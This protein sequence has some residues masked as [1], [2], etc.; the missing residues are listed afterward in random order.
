M[1]VRR[2]VL[3]LCAL[4]GLGFLSQLGWRAYIACLM[5]RGDYV[6]LEHFGGDRYFLPAVRRLYSPQGKSAECRSGLADWATRRYQTRFPSEDVYD[7]ASIPGGDLLLLLRR[8]PAAQALDDVQQGVRLVVLDP[9]HSESVVGETGPFDLNAYGFDLGYFSGWDGATVLVHGGGTG[10]CALLFRLRERKFTLESC[11]GRKEVEPYFLCWVG[12]KL[13]DTDG[14]GIPEVQGGAGK[15]RNCPAC[16]RDAEYNLV[17]W[18]FIDGAYHQWT[19]RG[20][21]CGLACELA[22]SFR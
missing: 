6:R 10:D 5:W 19:E 22:W 17:T 4:A 16:G 15:W 13:V 3:T 8:K 18:K 21:E 14:D 7:L 2:V 11:K 9:A 12:L 20:A 1:R